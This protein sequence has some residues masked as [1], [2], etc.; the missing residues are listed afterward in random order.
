MAI[1][2][3]PDEQSID[4]PIPEA[5]R[6]ALNLA[7]NAENSPQLGQ[8]QLSPNTE[9]DQFTLRLP[10]GEASLWVWTND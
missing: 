9:N 6:T 1:S 10:A 4:I 2:K 7:G 5:L 3:S 8:G